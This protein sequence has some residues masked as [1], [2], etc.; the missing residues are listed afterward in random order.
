MS[1]KSCQT[2]FYEEISSTLEP[3]GSCVCSS[4]DQYWKPKAGQDEITKLLAKHRGDVAEI[5]DILRDRKASVEPLDAL[6]D[7]EVHIV[8]MLARLPTP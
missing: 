7:I 4:H 2:C 6:E 5:L 3:C 8:D 1:S